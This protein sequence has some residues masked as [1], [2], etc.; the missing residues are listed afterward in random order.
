MPLRLLFLLLLLPALL[1][2]QPT[3]TSFLGYELGSRFTFHHRV[4]A[5]LEAVA[6]ASDRV[7]VRQYGTTP[8]GRPLQ[9][10]VLSAP[11]NL[12]RI[13]NLREAHLRSLGFQEG[14]A[15]GD[16][17]LVVW[18]GYNIHGDEAASTETALKMLHHLATSQDTTVTRWLR[19]MVILLDPCSNPDGRERYV[20]EFTQW[21]SPHHIS[22]PQSA[23]HQ[24]SYPWGRFNHYLFDLNRD[25]LWQVQPESQARGRLYTDWMPHVLVDFHEMGINASYF[26]PPSAEPIH[27]IVT[28]WQK[29]FQ[30]HIGTNHARYF[31]EKGWRY[32]TDRVFDL[33]YPSYGDTW[34]SF[35][36][37]IGMTY[38]QAGSRAAGVAV[39]QRNGRLLTLEDR[40]AHHFTSGISTLETAYRDRES[41]KT[42]LRTYF[43]EARKNGSGHH[44]TFVVRGDN[45]ADKLRSLTTLLERQQITYGTPQ[46]A[47]GAYSGFNYRSGNTERFQIRANDLIITTHQSQGRLVQVLFEPEPQR[48]DSLTYDLTAWAL[49]YSIGLKA[50]A[51]RESLAPTDTFPTPTTEYKT[52]DTPYAYLLEWKTASDARTLGRLLQAGWRVRAAEKP[53]IHSGRNW[54]AGT[55]VI[56]KIEQ[57]DERQAQF[58]EILEKLLREEEQ[59]VFAVQTGLSDTGSDLGDGYFIPLSKPKVGLL[60]GASIK[61]TRTGEIW[62]FLERELNYPVHLLRTE[63]L[64][65]LK[66][67]SYDVL[68]V[69][70]GKTLEHA[71]TLRRFAQ[72][73]GT[74]IVIGKSLRHFARREENS[75][76]LNEVSI[77]PPAVRYGG[78][79]RAQIST[80]TAGSIVPVQ[81]DTSHPLAFGYSKTYFSLKHE[82]LLFEALPQKAAYRNVGTFAAAP[83][84][85]FMGSRMQAQL[86]GKLALGTK[87]LGKGKMIY[88]ADAPTFRGFWQSGKLL[89]SNAI[90][91][92]RAF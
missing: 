30:Q 24:A 59:E 9:I 33:F 12:R 1:F 29:T 68:I 85:G 52:H 57:N 87:Q 86:K 15:A 75:E 78:S 40:I 62:H 65:K 27:P 61:E 21:Q 13:R 81:L 55:L 63:R 4:T 36:G 6:A 37:A 44:Q 76:V 60:A 5:Y 22:D 71:E 77:A 25:W 35:Q 42:Q 70:S 51:L 18:L 48:N 31:D 53:F 34:S 88:F 91:M 92:V 49:P 80:E 14:E 46:D 32:Y 47:G 67:R 54:A 66:L 20:Q 72:K 50:F 73:G 74:L 39:K 7:Q 64:P 90:F 28:D 38:E 26:F 16:P 41:L 23:E 43:A 82:S 84:S 79:K 58:K 17:P 89:L 56:N 10:A 8:E 19:E 69:P 2:A 11:E 3:P 83:R 45:P